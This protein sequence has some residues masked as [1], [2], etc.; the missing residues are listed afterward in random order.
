MDLVAL[1][2]DLA[3]RAVFGRE[4]DKC[5]QALMA[6]LNDVLQ[7]N[8]VQLSYNNPLNLQSYEEDKKSEMDIEI[9][10]DQGDGKCY[11]VQH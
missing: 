10:T 4:Y 6:L 3:F 8:I 2:S 5:K 7:L 11:L 1:K 9:T